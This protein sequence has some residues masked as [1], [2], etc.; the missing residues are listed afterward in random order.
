MS[1]RIGISKL[2]KPCRI[3]VSGFSLI[4]LLITI[5]IIAVLI[6]LLLPAFSYARNEA[7]Q[8][9]CVSQL[10]QLGLGF[11]TY[12]DSNHGLLPYAEEPV[13]ISEARMH[14]VQELADALGLPMP[15]ITAV[16]SV[17]AQP[18]W[19]CPA[20]PYICSRLGFSYRYEM[21]PIM[22][23]MGKENLPLLSRSLESGSNTVLLRDSLAFHTTTRSTAELRGKKGTCFLYSNLAII[24]E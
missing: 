18:P 24:A 6:S 15:T 10:R 8:T 13:S 12:A 5:S 11:V 17:Q 19:K 21:W 16:R 7:R 22:A 2:P 23:L 14:P 9:V 1:S 4:E 20:D 3:R